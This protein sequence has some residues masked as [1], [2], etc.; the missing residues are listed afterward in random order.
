MFATIR[1]YEGVD[2]SRIDELNRKINETL[3]PKRSRPIVRISARPSSVPVRMV[4][5]YRSSES[6][7]MVD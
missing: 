2:T 5:K 7:A 1:R 3:V 4:T 6:P